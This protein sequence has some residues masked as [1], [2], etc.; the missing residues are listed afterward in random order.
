M[1][2]IALSVARDR[3]IR[4]LE[5]N[6][7]QFRTPEDLNHAFHQIRDSVLNGEVPLAF[8]D[9]FDASFEGELGWL[10][11]FLVPMQD[12]VFREGDVLHPIGRAIFVFA[13]GTRA[14]FAEFAAGTRSIATPQSGRPHSSESFRAVKGPDFI[15][16]LRGFIDIIGPNPTGPN[17]IEYVVRRAML[18]RSLIERKAPELLDSKGDVCIDE[19]VLRALLRTPFY[20]HGARSMEAI[21]DMSKLAGK[22]CWEPAALPPASQLGLHVDADVFER[23]VL[24]DVLLNASRETL[25]KA[26]HECYRSAQENEKQSND[27]AMQPWE[28]LEEELRESNRQQADDIVA[29]LHRV[30]YGI[31]PMTAPDPAGVAFTDAEVETM[32]EMEHNRWMSERR[33]AGWTFDLQRDPAQKRTPYLVPYAELPEDAKNLDRSAVRAIPDVLAMAKFEI[34]RL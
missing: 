12:G 4:R 30:N 9:E 27:L 26:V 31:M 10:K 5:F 23:L 25:A 29:K 33:I 22:Q 21:M 17:E 7:S 16:R 1:T 2:E 24:R 15:S 13:G 8:F 32:A 20:T 3:R 14:S 6:L 28:S 18:L 11:Y 34:R 19:G